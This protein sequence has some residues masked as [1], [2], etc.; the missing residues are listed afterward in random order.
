M[1]VVLELTLADF[2]VITRYYSLVIEFSVQNITRTKAVN[3]MTFHKL[4]SLPLI[5]YENFFHCSYN[6]MARNTISQFHSH[7]S[8]EGFRH[9][10]I[11]TRLI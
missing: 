7:L 3:S 10:K 11:F 5:D 1:F 8:C 6:K 9:K 4:S 2:E